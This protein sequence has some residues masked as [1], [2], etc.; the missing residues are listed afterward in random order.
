MNHK[1]FYA[2]GIATLLFFASGVIFSQGLT[3]ESTTTLPIDSSKEIHSVSYYL[4]HMMKQTAEGNATIFR[5]DKDLFIRVDN[6]LKQ[7]S[8]MT[9]AELESEA[10]QA[11]GEL[12]ARMA[13]MKKRLESMPPEQRK[14]V[15]QMMGDRLKGGSKDAR[16]EVTKTSETKTIS[17]YT[18]TK[19]V[20]K[21]DDKD[22]ATIWTTAG[23]SGFSAMKDDFKEFSQR[24]MSMLPSSG[25]KIAAQMKQIDGFPI[26]SKIGGMNI[27]VNKIEERSIPASEFEP[28]AGYTKVKSPSLEDR[29][30]QH[31]QKEQKNE[32]HPKEKD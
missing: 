12:D 32:E 13:E 21:E 2:I 31:R 28:P 18:C 5:L 9:F 10:K 6:K 16:V 7:Y 19:Y 14:M 26:Q 15:E 22:F 25:A 8:E 3:W 30:R 27:T 20:I 24:I 4:P 17:G 11:S 1:I 29:M 23:I